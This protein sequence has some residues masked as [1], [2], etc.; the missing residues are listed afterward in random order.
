[1]DSTVIGSK[2]YCEYCKNYVDKLHMCSEREYY[3]DNCNTYQKGM[4]ACVI[5]SK[6]LSKTSSKENTP[7]NSKENTPSSNNN[8]VFT[9]LDIKTGTVIETPKEETTETVSE[10]IIETPIVETGIETLSTEQTSGT[11]TSSDWSS[12]RIGRCGESYCSTCDMYYSGWHS[13]FVEQQK[14]FNEKL[15]SDIKK[16]NEKSED[17]I[18]RLNEKLDEVMLCMKELMGEF[19]KINKSCD[20][21]TDHIDFVENVYDKVKKPLNF[22]KNSAA[23]LY[24]DSSSEDLPKITDESLSIK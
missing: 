24:G 18:K 9:D 21:M 23:K 4:H 16:I 2:S 7:S 12:L 19:K 3:C 14:K 15:T 11:T 13:C 22:L 1:M 8:F 6:S 10:M 5:I 20:K 17:E